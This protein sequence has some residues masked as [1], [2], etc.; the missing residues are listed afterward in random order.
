MLPQDLLQLL[1]R[2]GVPNETTQVLETIF[3]QR[4][5]DSYTNKPVGACDQ[6]AITRTGDVNGI[7]CV[8]AKN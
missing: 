7:H 1:S 8:N 5:H 2:T 6:N 4:L 3:E